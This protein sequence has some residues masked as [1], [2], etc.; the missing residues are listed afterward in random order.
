LKNSEENHSTNLLN[1]SSKRTAIRTTF[2][3]LNFGSGSSMNMT[4]PSMKCKKNIKHSKME[5]IIFVSV[6]SSAFPSAAGVCRTR[7]AMARSGTGA[8]TGSA[9]RGLPFTVSF[10]SRSEFLYRIFYAPHDCGAFFLQ[11]DI[12]QPRSSIGHTQNGDLHVFLPN[13][14]GSNTRKYSFSN[15]VRAEKHESHPFAQVLFHV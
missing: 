12:I 8:P 14:S 6:P 3:V 11:H 13:K 1:I 4:M 10:F 2:P 15:I 9:L 7:I 5:T